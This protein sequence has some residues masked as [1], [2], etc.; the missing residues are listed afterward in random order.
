ME[1]EVIFSEQ[2]PKPLGPYSQAVRVGNTLFVSGQIGI[3]PV[4]GELKRGVR[5]QT[6]QALENLKAILE[7][8]GFAVED[9]ALMIAFLKDINS[10]G[11]FNEVY[12]SYFKGAPPARAV[13]GASALPAGAEV[14]VL[15]VA[16]KR[17]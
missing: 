10:Y 16:V 17:E 1:R 13:V 8:A 12:S 7:A 2:A 6:R 15:A 4:T 9:V 3:D 11:E 14:E 5:E